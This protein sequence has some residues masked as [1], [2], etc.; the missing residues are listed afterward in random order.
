[1]A[2]SSLVLEGADKKKR[3][4]SSWNWTCRFV[5]PKYIVYC[6]I[7]NLK[8]CRRKFLIMSQII[9]KWKKMSHGVIFKYKNDDVRMAQH[10]Y[11][12]VKTRRSW[13]A[14]LFSVH[15]IKKRDDSHFSM[16]T[17]ADTINQMQI[18]A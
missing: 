17:V 6:L 7:E 9:S 14:M 12:Y 5:W 13:Y 2:V 11:W 15:L 18:N 1:M 16:Q 10:V 3:V 8:N 4:K